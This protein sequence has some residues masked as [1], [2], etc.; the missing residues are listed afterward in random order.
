MNQGEVLVADAELKLAHG[1]YKW[2]RFDISNGSSQLETCQTR[3]EAMIKQQTHFNN[4][5]IW[6]LISIVDRN[7]RN[8]FNPILNRICDMR[9]NLRQRHEVFLGNA[10]NA[11]ILE[12]FCPD[13]LLS[14]VDAQHVSF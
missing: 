2:R 10:S 13:I 8:A 5:D 7:L 11:F 9:D 14:S 4:T 12:Q 3:P 1:F 6:L